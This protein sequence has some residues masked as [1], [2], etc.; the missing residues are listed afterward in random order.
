MQRSKCRAVCVLCMAIM[1][2]ELGRMQGGGKGA[3]EFAVSKCSAGFCVHANTGVRKN[4][5]LAIQ[6]CKIAIHYG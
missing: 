3:K 2:G 5:H 6:S 1:Q 4:N